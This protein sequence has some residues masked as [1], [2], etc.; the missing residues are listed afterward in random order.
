DVHPSSHRV[1][2]TQRLFYAVSIHSS[3]SKQEH[4]RHKEGRHRPE[5]YPTVARPAHHASE[6]V[7]ERCRNDGDGKQFDKIGQR[8]RILERVRTIRV[9]KAATVSPHI[10]DNLHFPNPTL[11]I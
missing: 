11:T 8:C 4:P 2:D 3:T 9:E 6:G 1:A 5:N 10:F 7:R